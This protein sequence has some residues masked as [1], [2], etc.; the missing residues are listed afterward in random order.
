LCLFL[1]V[2]RWEDRTNYGLEDYGGS[3]TENQAAPFA[4]RVFQ[5]AARQQDE[6]EAQRELFARR[7]TSKS[8]VEDGEIKDI[9]PQSVLDALSTDASESTRERMYW[10]LVSLWEEGIDMELSSRFVAATPMRR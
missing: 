7:R 4:T 10:A 8:A 3:S 9:F 6:E 2:K 5:R 1:C